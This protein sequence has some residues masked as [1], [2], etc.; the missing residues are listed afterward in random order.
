MIKPTIAGNYILPLANIHFAES[1]DVVPDDNIVN[2][3]RKLCII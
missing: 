2:D 3:S 1:V